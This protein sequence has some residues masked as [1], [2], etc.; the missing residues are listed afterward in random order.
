[1]QADDVLDLFDWL[2][3]EKGTHAQQL[4]ECDWSSGHSKSQDGGL[5]PLGFN[6]GVGGKQTK[7]RASPLEH[8]A[9]VGKEEAALHRSQE[10]PNVWSRM[11][12]AAH[13]EVEC[14]VYVGDTH[15]SVS[16]DGDPPPFLDLKR[17]PKEDWTRARKPPRLSKNAAL[18]QCSLSRQNNREVTKI[19]PLYQQKSRDPHQ[20][21]L[22]ACN[23]AAATVLK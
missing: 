13:T 5:N 7:M 20:V 11:P 4:G 17:R 16:Q 10:D 14:R 6:K 21:S 12:M 15:H 8:P 9:C 23:K 18:F 22:H 2:D 1:V 3:I 19:K